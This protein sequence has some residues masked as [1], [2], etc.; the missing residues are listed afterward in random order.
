MKES[1]EKKYI[2]VDEPTRRYGD[3][4]RYVYDTAEEANFAAWRAWNYLTKQEQRERHIWAGL[5]THEYLDDDAID[6]D[7][8][9]IDWRCFVWADTFPGAFDSSTYSEGASDVD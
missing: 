3:E 4:W 7:T 9:K 6:E 1:V 8:G 2:V 5:V